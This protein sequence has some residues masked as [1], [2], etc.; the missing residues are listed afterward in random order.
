VFGD[1]SAKKKMA[2]GVIFLE[3]AP[4]IYNVPGLSMQSAK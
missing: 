1:A 2:S 3:L 4:L